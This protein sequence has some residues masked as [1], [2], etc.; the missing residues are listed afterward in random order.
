MRR[1]RV[2]FGLVFAGLVLAGAVQP[3][4]VR[5]QEG[6]DAQEQERLQKFWRDYYDALKRY[7]QTPPGVQAP[8]AP[9]CFR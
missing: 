9:P 6:K 4:P 2:L 8:P 3:R 5:G 7:Y 1:K